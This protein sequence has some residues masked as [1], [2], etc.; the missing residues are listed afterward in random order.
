M[1]YV[2]GA[3]IL[4]TV[5]FGGYM[6]LEQNTPKEEP[7]NTTENSV[8]LPQPQVTQNPSPA[9]DNAILVAQ[10]TAEF[11]TKY[12]RPSS[13]IFLSVTEN[14]GEFATG[15]IGF[16]EEVGGGLWFAAKTQSGW[17]LAYDGNGIVSCEAANKYDFPATMIPNCIDL[18]NNNELLTR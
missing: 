6:L 14:T 18:Q 8:E 2:L 13:D 11:M 5:V 12:N 7:L 4:I 10:I 9:N 17:K 3:L 15:V 16:K 1:K